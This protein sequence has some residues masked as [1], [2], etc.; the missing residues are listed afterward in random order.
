MNCAFCSSQTRQVMDFG[1]VALAGGFLMPKDFASEQRYPLRLHFCES[2]YAVQLADR[3]DPETLFRS[4][5]YFSSASETMRGHFRS[6]AADV[7]ERFKPR[8]VVEI[9]CN[10]GALLRPL[11]GLGVSVV[12]VDPSTAANDDSLPIINEFFTQDVANRIGNA[13][14]VIANNVFA[15]V[16]DIHGVTDA[17]RS[18]IGDDGVFVMEVH[19]LLAMVDRLQYDWIYHEHL[20]Y[21]SLLSLSKHVERHGLEVF[22]VENVKTHG[23]S[24][25]YYVCKRGTR[26]VS[27]QVEAV[28][29][30]E[31]AY[32]LDRFETF[33]RFADKAKAH[34]MKLVR[35]LAA[36]EVQGATVAGYGASGR[37]NALM[38][39]CGIDNSFMAY[40]VDDAPA[41]DGYYTPGTHISIHPRSMLQTC[42]PDYVLVFAW[43]YLDEIEP[44]CGSADLIVPFP[45][46]RVR[47]R[48]KVAA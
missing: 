22:D 10:D 33:K 34:A 35:F 28:L 4:Y 20:Y 24:R 25:R 7:V 43:T 42:P 38:Q 17:V 14:M 8:R 1:S 9:G 2:C 48:V 18:A 41:K 19:S 5:F 31:R 40:M 3:V 44:K 6:Y 39:F 15:H 36:L 16:P 47:E 13:D 30:A 21:Y 46:V 23:G 32:G 11:I 12:G 27:P 45:D 29:C 37:A 26:V